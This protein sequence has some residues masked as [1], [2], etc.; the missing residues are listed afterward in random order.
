MLFKTASAL[1]L[2]SFASSLAEAV[3]YTTY[4]SLPKFLTS[5][6]SP[7]PKTTLP[8]RNSKLTLL[9]PLP[10]GYPWGKYTATNVNPESTVPDTGV[11][12]K[13]TFSIS[14]QTYSPDGYSKSGILVNGQFPG[15]LIEA[16]WGDTIQVTV[17]NDKTDE[18]T[19][20]HW[21][22]L[23]QNLNPAYDG[24]PA[25]SQCPIAPGKSLTYTFRAEQYGTSWWHSHFSA[26]YMD[27]VYG[28]MVIYGF[29]LRIC[30]ST[31][32]LY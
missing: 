27:G 30:E 10:N 5:N 21:H 31:E 28:P 16:N 29:V 17:T 18:G 8:T 11:T 32:A 15:P 24:V 6:V 20:V 26:E 7:N 19:T 22:G 3:S 14:R 12:R 23:A 25:V 2:L 13:Y 1:A 9:Q 4:K